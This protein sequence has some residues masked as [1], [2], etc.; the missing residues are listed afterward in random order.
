ML[1]KIKKMFA[2]QTKEQYVQE[3]INRTLVSIDQNAI[4]ILN[5]EDDLQY[6]KAMNAM[7]TARL[8]KLTEHAE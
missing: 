3:Q 2:R 7:F 8:F 4:N 6:F 1:N 5:T